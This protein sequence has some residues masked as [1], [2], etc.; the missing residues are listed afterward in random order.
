MYT[1]GIQVGTV[2]TVKL[3]PIEEMLAPQD[4]VTTRY[5]GGA[6][7]GVRVLVRFEPEPDILLLS[8]ALLIRTETNQEIVALFKE[9]NRGRVI[10]ESYPD[11]PKHDDLIRKLSLTELERLSELGAQR[12]A[13][14]LEEERHEVESR[15]TRLPGMQCAPDTARLVRLLLNEATKRVE[16][17]VESGDAM[18]VLR[19]S[20]EAFRATVIEAYEGLHLVEPQSA[21]VPSGFV[22]VRITPP[23]FVALAPK[24]FARLDVESAALKLLNL[25]NE[26]GVEARVSAEDLEQRSGILVPL[27]NM[28]VEYFEI[29]DVVKSGGSAQSSDGLQFSWVSLLP[30]GPRLLRGHE[31]L[32]T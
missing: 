4:W 24:I 27:L 11:D 5:P 1:T 25:L 30:R 10:S 13:A 6:W 16:P 15:D 18:N 28:L 22:R 17:W 7:A 14:A 2:F 9:D 3:I 8:Y 23:G 21:A 29:R 12:L 31:V 19:I 20:P 32:L 26:A